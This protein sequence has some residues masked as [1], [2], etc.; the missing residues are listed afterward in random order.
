MKQKSNGIKAGGASGHFAGFH[1]G[2]VAR[3]VEPVH[4]ELEILAGLD[5]LDGNPTEMRLFCGG[6]MK[7]QECGTG[8]ERVANGTSEADWIRCHGNLNSFKL[9]GGLDLVL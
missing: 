2:F 3:L 4:V 5:L 8:E 7:K 9:T 6:G 1:D